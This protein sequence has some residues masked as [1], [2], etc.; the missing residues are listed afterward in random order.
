MT[1]KNSTLVY[2]TELGKTCPTCR[3]ALTACICKQQQMS[4]VVGDG[5]VRV[6][7]ETKGRGGKTAT[8]IKGL[9]INGEALV[10]LAKK[11]KTSCGSGGAIKDGVIE[12]QG[13]HCDKVMALMEKEG[14]KAKRSGG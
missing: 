1:N 12:I 14:I 11:L 10:V 7:R 6:S 8:V 9:A 2:S 4:R 3:M 5:T 13:D